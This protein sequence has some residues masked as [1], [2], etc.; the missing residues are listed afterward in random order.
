VLAGV[1]LDVLTGGAIRDRIASTVGDWVVEQRLALMMAGVLMFLAHPF[2]GVGP[3][4][5][6]ES[7][8]Q[9]GPGITWLWDYLPTAQNAYVQMAAETGAIGLAALLV[10]L[11]DG[12]RRLLRSARDR[13]NKASSSQRVLHNT[14]LWAFATACALGMVEWTFAHGVGQM[15]MLIAA[16]GVA[17]ARPEQEQRTGWP[18]GAYGQTSVN[19]LPAAQ[20][21]TPAHARVRDP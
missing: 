18:F 13:H 7:L 1:L 17:L 4:G 9:F 15:I 21:I 2:T 14:L 12:L 20:S 16:M 11:L 6:A 10:F 5:F 8:E 3:G 19:P